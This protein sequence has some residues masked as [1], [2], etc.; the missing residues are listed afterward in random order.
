MS[1]TE[2]YLDL[3]MRE[4]L[5]L[6]LEYRL[7]VAVR[8]NEPCNCAEYLIG[9]RDVLMPEV[10]KSATKRGLEPIELFHQFATK[11]H[12]QHEGGFDD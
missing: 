12:A 2:N 1:H 4:L 10:M 3:P 6:D 9:R 7:T 11:L 8:I 5:D